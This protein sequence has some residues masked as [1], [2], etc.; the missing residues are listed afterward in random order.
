MN[1]TATPPSRPSP[2][3]Y[4]LHSLLDLPRRLFRPPCPAA[5]PHDSSS[6]SSCARS[7]SDGS[8]DPEMGGVTVLQQ[9]GLKRMRLCDVRL[10]EVLEGKHLPPLG[11]K[12]FE[13]Y[14][15]FVE[16]SAENLYFEVWYQSYT[17]AFDS[18][19][20]AT[21]TLELSEALTSSYQRS[22]SIFLDPLSQLELN[23]D[24]E[25]RQELNRATA[26][27]EQR[28]ALSSTAEP[29]LPPSAFDNIRKQ[30]HRAL[31]SSFAAFLFTRA[32]NAGPNRARFAKRVS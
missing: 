14:L 28:V 15:C 32:Q 5:T 10:A 24:A 17:K 18:S 8:M 1:D 22:L 20:P 19:P 21:R 7:K 2:S 29:F 11:L 16:R 27:L 12:D 31:E 30:S 26:E 13:D 23:V 25:S 6:S 3:P 4:R 9:R